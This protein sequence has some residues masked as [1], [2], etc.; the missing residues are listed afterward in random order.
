MPLADDDYLIG[1]YEEDDVA[2]L[3]FYKNYYPMIRQFILKN[4]GNV[5]DAED[6]FQESLI[7]LIENIRSRKV[8][9]GEIKLKTYFYSI[10]RNKWLKK[11][12]KA[13]QM[14][15]HATNH[16]EIELT[17]IEGMKPIEIE[18]EEEE[19]KN[20]LIKKI[21]DCI[22]NLGVNCRKILEL[23]YFENKTHVQIAA[24]MQYTSG[25]NVRNQKYKCMRR[26]RKCASDT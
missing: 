2:I 18:A 7:A 10:A 23:F 1:L 6:I 20:D 17:D 3:D 4:S 24:E 12:R 21:L 26:L 13:K 8:H 22:N 14:A 11:L 5:Q 15:I 19:E 16:E 9:L 25:A